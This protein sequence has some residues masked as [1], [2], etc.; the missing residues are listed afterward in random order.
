MLQLGWEAGPG[1]FPPF[2]RFFFHSAHP[3]QGAFLESF[4]RDVL[5]QLRQKSGK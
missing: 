5:P 1:Q 2:D 4:A 3:D